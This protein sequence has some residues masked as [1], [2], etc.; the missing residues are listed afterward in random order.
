VFS[1][2]VYWLRPYAYYLYQVAAYNGLHP[3]VTSVYRSYQR[4]AVLY[5]NY[6]RGLSALPAAPPGRSKHQY[7]LAF[8]MVTDNAPAL[9]AFWESM[10]GKFGGVRDPVHFEAP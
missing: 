10:G 8:D 7:G 5:D 1:G 3:R 2:L 4:Q 9:G 6:R